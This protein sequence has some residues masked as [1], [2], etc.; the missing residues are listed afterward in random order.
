MHA[1]LGR[2]RTRSER[3]V[4]VWL[5]F[6]GALLIVRWWPASGR[7]VG[8]NDRGEGG[9]NPWEAR[10]EDRRRASKNTAAKSGFNLPVLHPWAVQRQRQFAVFYVLFSG[11][12]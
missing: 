11:R 3:I 5:L 7:A 12:R 8:P 2:A 4:F 10:A 9:L 1:L 6:G